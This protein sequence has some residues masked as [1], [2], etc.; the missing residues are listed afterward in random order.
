MIPERLDQVTSRPL[1]LERLRASY[2][3]KAADVHP[4]SEWSEADVEFLAAD[5]NGTPDQV[6]SLA[7]TTQ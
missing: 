5:I 6:R 1:D 4:V 3:K 7:R 2:V